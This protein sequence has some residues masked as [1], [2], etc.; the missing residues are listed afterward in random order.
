MIEQK[1]PKVVAVGIEAGLLAQ[2]R[3]PE[4][5]K[6]LQR[7]QRRLALGH[8]HRATGHCN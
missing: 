6:G 8:R 1:V 5:G 2:A 7:S 4:E 3:G